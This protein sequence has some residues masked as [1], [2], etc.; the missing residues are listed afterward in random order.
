MDTSTQGVRK[1]MFYHALLLCAEYQQHILKNL[2][3]KYGKCLPNEVISTINIVFT[4]NWFCNIYTKMNNTQND[5]MNQLQ[6]RHASTK[7]KEA[8][9]GNTPLKL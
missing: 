7:L 2:S 1:S 5:H 3:L 9:A 6:M 8:V 4:G